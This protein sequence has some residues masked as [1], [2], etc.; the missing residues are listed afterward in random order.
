M[1]VEHPEMTRF[2]KILHFQQDN[3]TLRV[4]QAV[5]EQQRDC[6]AMSVQKYGQNAASSV[7]FVLGYHNSHMVANICT[8][9][10]KTIGSWILLCTR[11]HMLKADIC[12]HVCT[13]I[14]QNKNINAQNA[15]VY[16]CI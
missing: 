2:L 4:Y 15:T 1:V 7:S 14:R 10:I 16:R 6:T 9:S 13:Y 5:T 3:E 11:W 12:I 8:F